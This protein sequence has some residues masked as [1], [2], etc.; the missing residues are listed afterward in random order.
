MLTK[1]YILLSI[2]LI[3]ISYSLSDV[4][5]IDTTLTCKNGKVEVI[6]TDSIALSKAPYVMDQHRIHI[7]GMNNNPHSIVS[8]V[9]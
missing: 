5:I 1:Q 7:W 4:S 9:C 2:F 6:V 8:F 3:S